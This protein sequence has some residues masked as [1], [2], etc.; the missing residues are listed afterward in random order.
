SWYRPSDAPA[1]VERVI[2]R[3]SR[4]PGV[5]TAAASF[6]APFGGHARHDINLAGTGNQPA[7]PKQTVGHHYVTPEYF[8]ALRIPPIRGRLFT[9]EDRLG[10]PPVAVVNRTAARRLW[11][12]EDPLGK[13]F[14]F[15]RMP[16]PQAD[17]AVEVVGIVE[18]VRYGVSGEPVGPDVYTPYYQFASLV[19]ALVMVRST[20]PPADLV[21]ALRRAVAAVERDLPVSEVQTMDSRGANELARRRL[22]A[23]LLST[24]AALA[25][26]I[27]AVGV[28]GVMAHQG[29]A[30]TREFGI[31]MALGAA[32]KDIY[33]LVLG[34][35]AALIAGGLTFGLLGALGLTRLLAAQLFDLTPTD[36]ATFAA[37]SG[38]LG[39]CAFLASYWPARRAT[40]VEPVVALR[41]E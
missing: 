25:L 12:G 22:N 10:R 16:N 21:P 23:L 6:Y 32:R 40:R 14:F 19:W 38:I 30:R 13:R 31:R 29:V 9:A 17:S 4:V 11:P 3:V 41:E 34:R 33:R 18:D 8:A 35:A 37:I 24:F 20:V 2:G 26:V 28:Y 15:R 39:A 7:G 1:L 27:A 5:E 36:P